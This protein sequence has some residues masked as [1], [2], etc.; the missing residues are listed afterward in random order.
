MESD[1]ESPDGFC[2]SLFWLIMNW[3]KVTVRQ[4]HVA[5]P[6]SGEQ[7]PLYTC[8]TMEITQFHLKQS[9]QSYFQK[10]RF[11]F[12]SKIQRVPLVCLR[13]SNWIFQELSRNELLCCPLTSQTINRSKG[14]PLAS[15]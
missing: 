10:Q 6:S 7:A 14:F 3:F 9:I 5:H 8:S 15:V 1:T 4:Q 13:K 2:Q 12:L 11:L